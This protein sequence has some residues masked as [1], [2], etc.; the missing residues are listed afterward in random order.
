MKP[1][2][3][4]ARLGWQRSKLVRLETATTVAAPEDTAALCDLYGAQDAER[5][6]LAEL[7]REARKRGWWT[8]YDDVLKGS[9][10]A[11]EAAASRIRFWEPQAVPVLLQTERYAWAMVTALR[12]DDPDGVERRV[13]ARMSRRSLLGKPDAPELVA[14]MDEA[15]LRRPVGGRD[16]MREQLESLLRPRPH[17]T[18]R[19]LPYA[20]GAHAGMEG[21]FVLL[22]FPDQTTEVYAE[23]FAGDL[24]PESAAEIARITLTFERIEQV[25]LDVDQSAHLIRRVIEEDMSA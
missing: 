14:I 21:G 13:T 24:Y 15:V 9:Y 19:A 7:A 18:V 22:D 11:D 10:V 20:A 8:A 1:E 6:L 2:E 12:P 3:V 23:G 17:V 16:V 4:A 25:A 5:A